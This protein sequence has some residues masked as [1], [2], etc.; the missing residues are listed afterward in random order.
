MKNLLFIL[1][2]AIFLSLISQSV[3]GK[4][5]IREQTKYYNVT[6]KTG[7]QVYAKFGRRGPWKIRR[8]H[9]IAATERE[10]DF[11]NIRFKERGNKCILTSVDVYLTLV[12]YYPRWLDKKRA[13]KSLQ[14]LWDRFYS[15]LVRHEETHGRYFKETIRQFEKELLKITGNIADD[16]AGMSQKA[17]RKLER[18]YSKAEARHD[19]FDRKELR[20]NSKVR[21][22]ERAFSKA[23]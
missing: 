16:C 6:G 18:I 20:S 21:V 14:K 9:A 11:K 23:K 5:I 8:K 15:E 10:F 17:Q 3:S 2:S 12:Y 19:A 4:V 1:V 22:L 7:S 13:S